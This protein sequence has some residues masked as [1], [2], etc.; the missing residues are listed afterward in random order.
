MNSWLQSSNKSFWA[1]AISTLVVAACTMVAG[2]SLGQHYIHNRAHDLAVLSQQQQIEPEVGY[3]AALLLNPN[4]STALSGLGEYYISRWQPAKA[5]ERLPEASNTAELR[6]TRAKALMELGRAENAA[7]AT[8]ISAEEQQA[9]KSG[10]VAAAEVLLQKGMPQ[11]ALRVLQSDSTDSARR[12]MVEASI[13]INKPG[14]TKE[15]Q[16]RAIS[17]LND[18]IKRHPV[19]LALQ[20][21]LYQTYLDL[22]QEDEANRQLELV[23]KL[24][25]GK[26]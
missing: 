10:G 26:F 21:Q 1:V 14:A 15:E 24:E 12:Y 25:A 16:E 23:Q 8:Q 18:G 4:E 22:G 20:K 2:A 9:I 3:Q 17:V 7:E 19:N 5:L 6:L 13:W 11:S